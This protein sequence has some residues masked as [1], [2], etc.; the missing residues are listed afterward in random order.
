M[1]RSIDPNDPKPMQHHRYS[2]IVKNQI[3][4]TQ[5]K[6]SSIH[7]HEELS[8]HDTVWEISTNQ[9]VIIIQKLTKYQFMIKNQQNKT[10]K[11][12]IQDILVSFKQKISILISFQIS[13]KQ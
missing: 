3:T 9:Q 8:I 1:C 6:F 11:V 10:K 5:W 13:T 12:F 7:K 4:G 2:R